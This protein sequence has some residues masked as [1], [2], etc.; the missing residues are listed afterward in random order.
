M[1]F[2]PFAVLAFL[3]VPG[4]AHAHEMP[5]GG[6]VAGL[7]HPVLGLDHLLAMVSVGVLSAQMGGRA[8]WTV[9][10]SFVGVMIVGGV[11]AMNSWF[12][13]SYIEMGIAFSVVFLGLA[14]A[15]ARKLPMLIAMAFVGFFA[16][17]HGYAHGLEIPDAAAQWQYIVGFVLGT[18]G[19]HLLGVGIGHAFSKI[20]HGSQALRLTGAC[21]MLTGVYILVSA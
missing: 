14:I 2:L 6:F 3:L 5:G 18:A 13:A 19:L 1:R 9:P 15:L 21:V 8:I 12:A 7:A 4:L 11:I 10:A 16:F 20:K 17:F